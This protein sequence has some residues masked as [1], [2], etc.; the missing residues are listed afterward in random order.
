MGKATG[1]AHVVVA[2][3][4]NVTLVASF[5][6]YLFLSFMERKKIVLASI[7]GIWGYSF[8][9]GMDAPIVR[10]AIMGSLAFGAQGLGR[11]N[12]AWRA[13]LTSI[14]IMLLVKPLFG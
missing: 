12:V 6:L 5:L 8:I 10:V 4:T 7:F 3:G 1:T 9:S 13:L 14:V 2:S 11:V